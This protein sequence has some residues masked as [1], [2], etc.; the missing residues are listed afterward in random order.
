MFQQVI[1][2]LSERVELLHTGVS[3]L[4]NTVGCQ[5]VA[6]LMRV[7]L[8]QALGLRYPLTLEFNQSTQER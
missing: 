4:L 2:P 7:L 1:S 3:V 8:E 6:L 5:P